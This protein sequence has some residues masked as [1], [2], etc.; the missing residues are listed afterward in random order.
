MGVLACSFQDSLAVLGIIDVCCETNDYIFNG[1]GLKQ[2]SDR[3][4]GTLDVSIA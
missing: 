1:R 4:Y 3:V 2:Q